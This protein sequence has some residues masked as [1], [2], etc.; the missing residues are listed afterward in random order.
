MK[1]RAKATSAAVLSLT[2]GSGITLGGAAGTIVLGITAT[3]TSAIAAG[4]YFYDLELTSGS[5]VTRL[6]QGEFLLTAE[7]TYA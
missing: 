5:T 6:L 2:N 7:I 3:Q 4:K 1:L